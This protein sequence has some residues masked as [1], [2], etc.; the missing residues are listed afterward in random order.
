MYIDPDPSRETCVI[1][2]NKEH[3]FFGIATAKQNLNTATGL[4]KKIFHLNIRRCEMAEIVEN[5]VKTYTV[6]LSELE[7]N[8]IYSAVNDATA[9]NTEA[10]GIKA[11]LMRCFDCGRWKMCS[12]CLSIFHTRHGK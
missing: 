11:E 4:K 12:K 8:F 3:N 5:V 7:V 10:A 9:N 2:F 1:E 6:K